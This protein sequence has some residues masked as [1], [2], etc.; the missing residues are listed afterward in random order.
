MA[1]KKCVVPF[2]GTA[3]QETKLLEMINSLKRN[4]GALMRIL[5]EAQEIYGYLPIEVQT[6]IAG[7]L[8]IPLEKV[9]GVVTFYSQFS[10]NPKGKYKVS[11]CMG[12]A[13]YVK[14]AGEILEKVKEK[15]GIDVGGVTP[16]ALFSLEDCRCV[17]ACGLAP[18]MMINDDVYGR[19]TGS[20][21]D[22]IFDK[23]RLK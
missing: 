15:L 18:V 16:D 12:T 19:L 14:G 2:K 3:A 10:L 22:G 17:G 9:Y 20:E 4:D 21:L 23:Y 8:G 5:Q 6:I 11:V 13:C 7:E 1:L